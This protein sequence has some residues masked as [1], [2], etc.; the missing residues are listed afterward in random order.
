[1]GAA[2]LVYTVVWGTVSGEYSFVGDSCSGEY[3]RVGTDVLVN[4]VVW[5]TVVLVETVVWRTV[6]WCRQSSGVYSLVGQVFWC[7]Q[8]CGVCMFLRRPEKVGWYLWTVLRSQLEEGADSEEELWVTDESDTETEES[9][10][11]DGEDV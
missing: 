1:M 2:V 4:T 5:Q 11:G 8:C 7:L 3:S 9:D 10:S 6:V